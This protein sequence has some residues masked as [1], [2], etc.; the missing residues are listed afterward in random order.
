LPDDFGLR[1]ANEVVRRR[2]EVESTPVVV[3]AP[4]SRRVWV[5]AAGAL[6]VAALVMVALVPF[7]W[8]GA[9]PGGLVM[10]EPVFSP[11][12]G[13]GV[14]DSAQMPESLVYYLPSSSSRPK[15]SL[16]FD[17]T[18]TPEGQRQRAFEEALAQAGVALDPELR[19]DPVL[20]DRLLDSRFVADVEITD[21]R[22][23]DDQVEMMYVVCEPSQADQL[24]LRMLSRRDEFA[25]VQLD[26]VQN[27]DDLDVFYQLNRTS[28]AQL[29]GR[30][31]PRGKRTL[32]Q[33]LVFNVSLRSSSLGFL[34]K[35]P[36][37]SIDLQLLPPDQPAEGLRLPQ[38]TPG[39]ASS[40]LVPAVPSAETASRPP[41]ADRQPL[42]SV[43]AAGMSEVVF[44]LR[45]LRRS[46]E[47][48]R[49]G[50][51]AVE[52]GAGTREK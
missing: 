48:L 46:V 35:F 12:R 1:V 34:A 8:Q 4:R 13:A 26:L 25:W 52:P 47:Q 37:P 38:L 15:Y 40:P 6:S 19:L 31:D 17:V 20:R 16:V 43:G 23:S 32:A 2:S 36:S 27:P 7:W 39:G 33:R 18:L 22:Q 45:L 11:P 10:R 9:G 30:V 29:A 28:R 49:R 41:A 14:D 5:V 3:D 24:W 21:V 44:V 51:G 42:A 50:P